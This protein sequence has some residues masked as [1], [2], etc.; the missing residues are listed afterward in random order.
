MGVDE[1]DD[2]AAH[3]PNPALELSISQCCENVMEIADGG[4]DYADER[5]SLADTLHTFAD[6][7]ALLLNPPKMKKRSFSCI[8]R[9]ALF[10]IG[11][12]GALFGK[13]NST[14]WNAGV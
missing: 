4:S 8:A 1:W 13:S 6:K 10:G 14:R 7:S 11:C 5:I 2:E 12:N 9:K 3:N